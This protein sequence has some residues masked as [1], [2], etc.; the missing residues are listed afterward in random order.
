MTKQEW[1]K[2]ESVKD[3]ENALVKMGY[4]KE[5]GNGSSHMKFRKDGKSLSVPDG[6]ILSTGVKRTL[7]KQLLGEKYYE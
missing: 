6:K 4:T 2:I 5:K 7:V 3:F 1:M